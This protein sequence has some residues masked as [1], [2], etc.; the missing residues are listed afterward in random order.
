MECSETSRGQS[1]SR[2]RP[3][4]QHVLSTGSLPEAD[5]GACARATQL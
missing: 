5:G 3:P 1:T 2:I 4:Q